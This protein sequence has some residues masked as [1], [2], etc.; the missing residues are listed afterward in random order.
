M[1]KHIKEYNTFSPDENINEGL[2]N[3][4]DSLKSA[5]KTLITG[6][7][8]TGYMPIPKVINPLL[9]GEH[10]LYLPHQQGPKGAA[11]IVKILTGKDKLDSGLRRNMYNNMPSSDV[12]YMRV[13]KGDDIDAVTAFLEYQKKTWD[14]YKKEG[15]S[16]IDSIENNKVKNA[17]NSVKN[18]QLPPGFLVTV[19]YKESRFVPNPTTNK[20]YTG[21]FQIG[22][23]AWD[24]LKR[25]FPSKYTGNKAPAS[26]KENS[27]AGYDY[28]KLAYDQFEK[29]LKK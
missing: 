21:L 18:N 11:R 20:T 13:Y 3:L 12:R 17:I 7:K 16:K 9:V 6:V 27:Q 15:A 28:I 29:L 26:P 8:S 5:I 10:M 23:S 19:A 24:E 22:P 25:N 4:W 14:T 2:Y 1:L